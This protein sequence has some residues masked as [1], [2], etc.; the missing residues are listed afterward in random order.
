MAVRV[1]VVDDHEPF[2]VWAAKLLR[3]GGM[4]VVG[5]A[6][7]AR[8]GLA[9]AE[10]LRPDVVL[11]DVRLP[12]IDGF[13]VCRALSATGLRVVLCSAALTERDC[14]D[15]VEKSG[16]AGFLP[17]DRLSAAALRLVLDG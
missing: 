11:L 2:R 1:L 9:D 4:E 15:L 8:E 3:A 6:A 12:D 16:A 17:K 14:R 13:T 7:T 5:E 10:T